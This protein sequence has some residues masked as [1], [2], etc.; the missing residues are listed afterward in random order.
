MSS[1][2]VA[3]NGNSISCEVGAGGNRNPD[4]L[5]SSEV[6]GSYEMHGVDVKNG[7]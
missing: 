1:S 3:G 4:K 5:P 7:V 6:S 2:T